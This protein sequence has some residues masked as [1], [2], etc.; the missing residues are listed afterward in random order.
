MTGFGLSCA[1]SWSRLMLFLF[2]V[3]PVPGNKISL[4]LYE[5]TESCQSLLQVEW[6]P[7]RTPHQNIFSLENGMQ[8][9]IM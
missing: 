2:K 8:L 6:Q 3:V 9:D 7:D 5:S 4:T 1:T